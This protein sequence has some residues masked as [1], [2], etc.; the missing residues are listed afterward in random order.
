VPKVSVVEVA[1]ATQNEPPVRSTHGHW[2]ALF[3]LSVGRCVRLSQGWSSASVIFAAPALRHATVRICG[4]AEALG[5][6]A[7]LTRINPEL[8]APDFPQ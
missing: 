5:V 7:R 3:A 1:P 6:P 8:S 2:H 4:I